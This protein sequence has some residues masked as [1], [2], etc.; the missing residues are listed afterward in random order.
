MGFYLYFTLIEHVP[1]ATYSS[2]NGF[3]SRRFVLHD[4]HDSSLFWC[5]RSVGGVTKV[6]FVNFSV[7]AI[8]DLAKVPLRLFESHLNLSATIDNA[9][10]FE[11]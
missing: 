5:A 4:C 9:E 1:T 7:S 8:V 2:Q 6:P 10:K 3:E 11:K